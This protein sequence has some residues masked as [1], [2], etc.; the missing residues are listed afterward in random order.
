MKA[1]GSVAVSLAEVRELLAQVAADRQELLQ[2]VRTP[3]LVVDGDALR[4]N[5]RTAAS[6]AQISGVAIRPHVK[7]HKCSAILREQLD[8]GSTTGVTCA[9]AYEAET[10]AALGFEDILVANEVVSNAGINA[11][12]GAAEVA[13]NLVVAVDS[14]RG[15]WAASAVAQAA[16]HEIG[17]LVDIDVGSGRCGV[18][19]DSDTVWQLAQLASRHD[20]LRFEGIMGYTGRA[21]YFASRAERLAVAAEVKTMLTVARRGLE[22]HGMVPRTISG[23]STGLFDLDQGL[24]ES[25]MGSYALMEGRYSGVGLPFAPALFCAATVISS[26]NP[27]HVV[28]DCGWKAL[29]GEYGFPLLP[30]GL[31]PVAFGDEHLICIATNPGQFTIGDVIVVLPAHLDPTMNLHERLLLLEG[32]RVT[33][34][35]IDLRRTGALLSAEAQTGPNDITLFSRSQRFLI[36]A[37][38]ELV[39]KNGLVVTPAGVIRGG[40]VAEEGVITHVGADATI[41][42]RA[43]AIDA[44]GKWVIPGIIDPHTHV[45]GV[46]IRRRWT[47]CGVPGRPRA[48]VRRTR[49]S[50]RSSVS[51]AAHR[52]HYTSPTYLPLNGKSLGR[53]RCRTPTSRFT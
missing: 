22:A 25:Q 30:P 34:W 33:E 14:Q 40:L 49:G 48:G 2:R 50:R 23:G 29:S 1:F 4:A 24:T 27:T 6:Q 8:A 41:P 53:S 37:R 42:D 9:T 18:A 21:N 46:R 36:G 52:G 26:S 17:V 32:N 20:E 5:C 16:G 31:E 38:M 3:C 35:P 11:L 51:T 19:A 12:V 10:L 15:I 43:D 39:V 28:L 7:A 44:G 13:E 45:G 47:E